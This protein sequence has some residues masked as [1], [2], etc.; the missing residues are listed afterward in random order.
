MI[1]NRTGHT[2]ERDAK[3]VEVVE[4]ER[5]R[6]KGGREQKTNGEVRVHFYMYMFFLLIVADFTISCRKRY[7]ELENKGC[8][9]V[10][11]TLFL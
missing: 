2:R 7:D 5:E 4:G 6:K 1:E 9:F 10:A 8:E 11:E 3:K